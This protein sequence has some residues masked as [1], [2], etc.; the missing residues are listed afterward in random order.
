[1][2]KKDKTFAKLVCRRGQVAQGPGRAVDELL[3]AQSQ[4]AHGTPPA[5]RDLKVSEFKFDDV[6]AV[7][8]ALCGPRDPNVSTASTVT[9]DAGDW[10]YGETK[11]AI[12]GVDKMLAF[13]ASTASA[14]VLKVCWRERC[15]RSE[16]ISRPA[17]LFQS[18][19][20]T[21]PTWQ[22]CR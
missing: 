4:R 11:S 22:S 13:F 7:L 2:L 16:N 20:R 21:V 12:G 6:I 5:A 15:F 3:S 19:R 1:M 9:Q 17:P 8:D 14:S 18:F 10:L